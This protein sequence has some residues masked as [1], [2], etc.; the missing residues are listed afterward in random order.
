MNAILLFKGLYY[1]LCSVALYVTLYALTC[2]HYISE[3]PTVTFSCLSLN[4]V[5]EGGNFTCV[6]KGI[7][8]NPPANVTWFKDDVQIVGP[9][10]EKQTLT[11]S[12]IGRTASGK[13]KCV[14]QSHTLTDEK[15]IEII[16]YYAVPP[17]VI[18]FTSTPAESVVFGESVVITCEAIAVP[19]PSY[20]IIH[21]NTEIVSTHKT[22]I[23]NDLTYSHAGPYKC[24]AANHLG[25]SSK[26]LNLSVT[27]S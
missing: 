23:I 26:I 22:F 5:N 3:K 8:G 13:Y 27:G 1:Y 25:N 4:K 14:A 7:G 24:I 19:V 17:T 2:F 15:A 20:T 16:V 12:N 10:K 21:N 6:C 18:S 11:F 9:G